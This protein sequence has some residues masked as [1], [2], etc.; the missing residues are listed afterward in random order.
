[1]L[2]LLLSCLLLLSPGSALA[3]DFTC[4]LSQGELAVGLNPDKATITIYGQ[5]P[6]NTPVIL[7][8][9]GPK[10]PVLVSLYQDS[11]LMKFNEAEVQ[12]LP[13]YYQILTTEPIDEIEQSHWGRLG[14]YPDFQQLTAGAWVRLRQDGGEYAN[15]N[16][17]D[18]IQLALKLKEEKKLFS[19]RQEVVQRNGTEYWA[20]LPLVAG[21]PL[22][23]LQVTALMI[24]NN[25]VLA[26]EQQILHVKPAS[27]LS[28]GAQDLSISAVLVISLFMVPILLLTVAQVLEMIE[29][30]KEQERRSELLKQIWQ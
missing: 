6:V 20:E 29:Q 5:A 16:Q 3:A 24:Q 25:Q 22:G 14:I 30:H 1:M 2:L 27:I 8:I 26:A 9:E 21:M 10:R 12:G 4:E 15:R 17:Q 13:G 19:L 28:L 11:S 7:K 23:D 18:Y